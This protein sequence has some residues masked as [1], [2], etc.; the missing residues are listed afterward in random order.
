MRESFSSDIVPRLMT[1]SLLV[2]SFMFVEGVEHLLCSNAAHGGD[3]PRCKVGDELAELV[4]ELFLAR[5]LAGDVKLPVS[6]LR[7]V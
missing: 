6:S 2:S 3:K 7:S 4:V 5:C 1:R